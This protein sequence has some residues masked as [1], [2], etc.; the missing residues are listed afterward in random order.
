MT[1]GR[2]FSPHF[3]EK[4]VIFWQ[5]E[6]TLYFSAIAWFRARAGFRMGCNLPV[7]RDQR[8]AAKLHVFFL[9]KTA[10]F[11]RYRFITIIVERIGTIS[12]GN[13]LRQYRPGK[14]PSEK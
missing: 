11:P 13:F 5:P 8:K 12:T 9:I 4:P 14:S 2:H 6:N 3:R 1:A 7:F 10:L